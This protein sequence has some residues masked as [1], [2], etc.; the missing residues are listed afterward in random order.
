MPHHSNRSPQRRRRRSKHSEKEF[1]GEKVSFDV[2]FIGG[3]LLLILLVGGGYWALKP[4]H[5][6]SEGSSPNPSNTEQAPGSLDPD[7]IKAIENSLSPLEIAQAFTQEKDPNKRLEWCR[8]PE[9]TKLLF[10][11]FTPEALTEIPKEVTPMPGVITTSTGLLFH[12]FVATFAN[13][14]QRLIPVVLSKEGLQVDWETYARHSTASWPDILQAQ[15]AESTVRVFIQKTN[16]YNYRYDD[17]TIWQAYEI[18]SP[19]IETPI[20]AYSERKSKFTKILSKFNKPQR[21]TLSIQLNESIKDHRQ[22]QITDLLAIGWV[23]TD[24]K[25]QLSDF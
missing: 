22:C 12:R 9:K 24:Q 5:S 6:D 16:Y 23:L 20:Y 17:D 14:N 18:T 1:E 4:S 10:S 2:F 7:Y 25:P 13:D 3:L 15:V 11:Q 19:D 8:H 21:A